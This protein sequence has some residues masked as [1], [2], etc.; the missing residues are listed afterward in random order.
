MIFL[1][2]LSS[3]SPFNPS[4]KIPSITMPPAPSI[5]VATIPENNPQQPSPIFSTEHIKFLFILS[6]WKPVAKAA[7]AA[8]I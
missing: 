8:V 4:P 7:T 3:K 2:S 5:T 6:Y 1:I